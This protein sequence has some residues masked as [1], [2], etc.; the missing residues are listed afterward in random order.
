MKHTV[1]LLTSA[2]VVF[3]LLASAGCVAQEDVSKEV[4]MDDIFSS[5]GARLDD[6]A[7]DMKTASGQIASGKRSGDEAE[8]VL[9][10][11]FQNAS[12]AQSILYADKNLIVAAAYPDIVKD[13]VGSDQHVYGTDETY[14]SGRGVRLT[15]C[16]PL[17]DGTNNCVLAMPVYNQERKFDGYI[18]MAFNTF[19]LLDSINTNI[20]NKYGHEFYVVQEDGT[21]IYDPDMDEVGMN[22]LSDSLYAA[23]DVKTAAEA[24]CRDRS[25]TA[26]YSFAGTNTTDVIEKHVYWDTFSYGGQNW[27]IV[28]A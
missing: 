24:I 27:R 5:I 9:A 13:A 8:R 4:V 16:L 23:A 14:F 2:A 1:R 12:L 20:K 3:C 19:R 11:L 22:I 25:G 15:D 6:A 21:Q 18:S 26:V 28:L 7:A 10:G 17:E